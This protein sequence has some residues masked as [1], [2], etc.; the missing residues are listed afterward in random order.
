[1]MTIRSLI[2]RMTRQTRSDT[3]NGDF[4]ADQRAWVVM[5]IDVAALVLVSGLLLFQRFLRGESYSLPTL[6]PLYLLVAGALISLLL[7]RYAG[8]RPAAHTAVAAGM[9]SVWFINVRYAPETIVKTETVYLVVACILP[10]L[11]L[12]RL[13]MLI[14]GLGT[15][16]VVSYITSVIGRGGQVDSSTTFDYLVDTSGAVVFAIFVTYV[17]SDIYSRAL[18]RVRRLLDRQKSQNADL[19]HMARIIKQS[20]AQTRQ[21]YR[22][23]IYSITDGKLSICD[24]REIKPILAS[25]EIQI[26]VPDAAAVSSARNQVKACFEDR[27]LTGERLEDFITAAGEAITNA[28]KHGGG[29]CVRAGACD[30]QVWLAVSDRG[31]GIESLTLPKAVLL[32]G[33]STKPSLGLGYSVILNISDS[34]LLKTDETGTTVVLYKSIVPADAEVSFSNLPDTWSQTG[35]LSE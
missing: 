27:G 12:S 11:L 32:R 2:S 31:P 17:M 1:M 4:V 21:F 25:A 22:D 7:L 29:G 3:E 18:D 5:I 10:A 6:I 33:F 8:Y 15:L 16:G 23:T 13:W 26:E 28:V 9:L 19:V 30:N 14:Y 20:E 35:L 24:A 34:V